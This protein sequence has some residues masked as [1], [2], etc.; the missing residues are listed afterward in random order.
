V[1]R[2]EE[3]VAAAGERDRGEGTVCGR[4]VAELARADERG[5]LMKE[6]A[7][8][9]A[10][11]PAQAINGVSMKE[12]EVRAGRRVCEGGDHLSG[13]P[14]EEGGVELL[15]ELLAAVAVAPRAAAGAVA[16]VGCC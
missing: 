4:E 15:E 9:P 12:T 8:V 7:L 13:A 11:T 16:A 1:S 5:V 6:R 10:P 3:R 14:G 2:V